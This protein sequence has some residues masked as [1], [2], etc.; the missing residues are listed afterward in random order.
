MTTTKQTKS[1]DIEKRLRPS[2]L[3]LEAENALGRAI[4]VLAVARTGYIPTTLDLLVRLSLAPD[5]QLRGVDLC[6]QL[7]KSA[8]Y[9]SRVID[10]AVGQGLVIRQLDPDDRRAQ[11]I[12]LTKAGEDALAVVIPASPRCPRPNGVH[13]SRRQRDRDS[14]RPTFQG[15]EFSPSASRITGVTP[16]RRSS[17]RQGRRVGYA[18][19][20][21]SW[22]ES[23]KPGIRLHRARR[24][25][26]ST[27][28]LR[29]SRGSQTSRSLSGSRLMASTKAST[30]FLALKCCFW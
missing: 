1:R 10:H 6:R 9:V 16:D 25:S 17:S 18:T 29:S 8:G 14:D 22:H 30:S 24:Q 23:D 27:S 28:C 11:R 19:T 2:G 15:R 3:L 21:S 7:L 13:R 5:Q 12:S 26:H 20:S 4:D